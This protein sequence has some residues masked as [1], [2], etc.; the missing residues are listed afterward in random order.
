MLHPHDYVESKSDSLAPNAGL[1]EDASAS[2]VVKQETVAREPNA[3]VKM[4]AVCSVT[5]HRLMCALV[6][7]S[8]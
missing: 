7:S 3:D 6:P 2:A 1:M 4:S 8:C 5:S